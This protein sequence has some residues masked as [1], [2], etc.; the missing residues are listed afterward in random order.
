MVTDDRLYSARFLENVWLQKWLLDAI[1]S[2]TLWVWNAYGKN[3]KLKSITMPILG[4]IYWDFCEISIKDHHIFEGLLLYMHY[5]VWFPHNAFRRKILSPLFGWINRLKEKLSNLSEFARI[6][7]DN[8]KWIQMS[9]TPKYRR[10]VMNKQWTQIMG[11]HHHL[12][13]HLLSNS[14]LMDNSACELLHKS[15][16]QVD[17]GGPN[18]YPSP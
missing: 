13:G 8:N 17:N 15:V 7:R 9:L 5:L 12:Y 14:P 3:T 16:W 1:F 4:C 6:R 10:T 2:P 11:K 18:S